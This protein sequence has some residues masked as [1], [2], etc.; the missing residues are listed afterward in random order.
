MSKYTLEELVLA[1][2]IILQAEEEPELLEKDT[3]F[4][5]QFHWACD[6]IHKSAPGL[7]EEVL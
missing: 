7:S 1:Y 4:W 5:N 6:V 2:Q 3:E